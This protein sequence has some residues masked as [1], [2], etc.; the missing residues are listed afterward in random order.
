MG[1]MAGTSADG[2]DAAT[3]RIEGIGERMQVR[4]LHHHHRAFTPDLRRRLLAIM[5]P[6][7]TRT[8]EV[9][10]LHAA[11]GEAFGHVAREAIA[12][13]PQRERPSLIGLAG[14]TVC[15]LPKDRAGRTV[16]LQLGSPA[17]VAA[18]TELPVVA[19]FRQSDVAAGGQGAP[20]VP[21][22]DW[23][24]LR[25]ARI[26][27]AVQNIGGIGNVTW[28]PAGCPSSDVI[29]FDTGPGNMV[30]DGLM[31]RISGG[32]KH[33][34]HDGKLARSGRVIE[35]LLHRWLSNPFFRRRP[36]R[37]TG[38]E[39]FGDTFIE[40]EWRALRKASSEPADWV[41]TATAL[42]AQSIVESYR[43]FIG[44]FA[45]AAPRERRHSG[46]LCRRA[47]QRSVQLILTGGGSRNPTLRR[48]LADGVPEAEVLT[49][50]E[51]GI[52]AQAKEAVSFALLAAARVDGV[53]GNLP[54][55]TG[56]TRPVLLGSLYV[57]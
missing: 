26:S 49:I 52:P 25:H 57:S 12:Q 9:A 36:P 33:M 2:I 50:D 15:H 1:L 44:A 14:Q 38:R 42:T 39:A 35:P 6:A 22:T 17:H 20:L 54:Q 21:W 46:T 51:L 32:R 18:I 40:Q 3:A 56:A 48:M 34:D 53:P 13:L 47:S 16:T 7:A 4:F 41:A 31:R 8:E 29:A 28:I 37:T 11:L 27:R 24:M 23:V 5:A 30:I 43:R 19:D 45:N 55:V 10:R